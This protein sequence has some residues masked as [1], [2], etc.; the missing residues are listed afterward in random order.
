MVATCR[1]HGNAQSAAVT[2]RNVYA[3]IS[4]V[5]LTLGEAAG[6][7]S[8]LGRRACR[9][10]I[11]AALNRVRSEATHPRLGLFQHLPDQLDN[12]VALRAQQIHPPGLTD[13]SK[14]HR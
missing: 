11:H 14:S 13:Q 9:A 12:R 1:S 4:T 7:R 8:L 2:G 3:A 10:A 6:W 5:Q